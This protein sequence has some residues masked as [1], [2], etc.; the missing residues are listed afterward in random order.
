MQSSPSAPRPFMNKARRNL[1]LLLAAFVLPIGMA[2]LVLEQGWYQGGS[3]NRGVLVAQPAPD[4]V[5]TPSSWQLMYVLP[6]ACDEVCQAALFTLRQVPQALGRKQDRVQSSVITHDKAQK[7]EVSGDLNEVITT[8]T[9]SQEQ[10]QSAALPEGLT[11]LYIV[12]PLGNLVMAYPLQFLEALP[13]KEQQQAI[14]K[15]GKDTFLDL[16]RLLKLSKVG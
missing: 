8:I 9:I 16:K 1:L 12:D 14:L 2:K 4:W 13:E 6:E 15:L 11:A 7:A 5:S 3:T 10:Y